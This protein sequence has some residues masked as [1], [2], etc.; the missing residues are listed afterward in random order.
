MGWDVIVD[1][2]LQTKLMLREGHGVGWEPGKQFHWE[3]RGQ[4]TKTR[5]LLQRIH[6]RLTKTTCMRNCFE[7][8]FTGAH[9]S[10][11]PKKNGHF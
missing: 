3:G 6:S 2:R 11:L 4:N 1:T 8:G 7:S 10:S 5:I 9:I